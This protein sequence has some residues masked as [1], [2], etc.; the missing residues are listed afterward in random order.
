MGLHYEFCLGRWTTDEVS[1]NL[2]LEEAL[3]SVHWS[4]APARGCRL[5]LDVQRLA[6]SGHPSQAGGLIARGEWDILSPRT[7][8][9][10]HSLLSEQLIPLPASILSL[11]Q[12]TISEGR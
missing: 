1:P 9:A 12:E 11:P 7:K 2:A 10:K 3:G 6:L 4:V 8:L 5:P